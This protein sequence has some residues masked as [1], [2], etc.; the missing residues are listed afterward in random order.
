MADVVL[1]LRAEWL[2]LILSG[3]KTAEF[4]RVMPKELGVGDRVYL[5]HNRALHGVAVVEDTDFVLSPRHEEHEDDCAFTSKT[6]ERHGCVDWK[7]I[8]SYLLGGQRA[9]VILLRDVERYCVPRPWDG[10]VVQNFVYFNK[11]SRK[12]S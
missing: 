6:Y 11:Q 12:E 7:V 8:F 9:G 3:K 10:S 1:A 2:E 4:R 5:Y